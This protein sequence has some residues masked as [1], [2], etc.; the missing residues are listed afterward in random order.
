MMYQ[1]KID[2]QRAL[3]DD[4]PI[5]LDVG[6][7][8]RKFHPEAIGIDITDHPDVDIVGDIFDVL[9]DLPTNR[10]SQIQA[11]HFLE[12]IDDVEGFLVECS[13]VLKV[14]GLI[15]ISVPHFSSPYFYSDPTHRRFFGLYS[16]SYLVES[17]LFKRSVPSYAQSTRSGLRL[18]RVSLNFKAPREFPISY[19]IL[20]F[21]G[22]F[23]DFNRATQEFYE[24]WMTGLIPCY[25]IAYDMRKTAIQDGRN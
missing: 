16:L 25:E 4:E 19:G 14:N 9:R 6:C 15:S 2:I 7:G 8:N 3:R 21:I 5:V 18:E 24:R 1:S 13:R 12:H 10:I 22:L 20:R 17:D 11:H 23:A